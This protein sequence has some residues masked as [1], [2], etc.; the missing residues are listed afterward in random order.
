VECTHARDLALLA[1]D[2]ALPDAD[3]GALDAHLAECADCRRYA[4]DAQAV[5]GALAGARAPEV[6]LSLAFRL[7]NL[8]LTGRAGR[9]VV[10]LRFW[11]AAAAGFLFFAAS[12]AVAFLSREPA[13]ISSAASTYA[14]DQAIDRALADVASAIQRGALGMDDSFA[15]TAVG[16]RPA[17]RPGALRF[18]ETLQQIGG[19]IEALSGPIFEDGSR[20][21]G[22]QG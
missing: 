12:L 2:G 17:S 1:A 21:E 15:M 9:A 3:R 19:Q 7:T 11:A 18:D 8:A 6:P 22:G 10:R 14:S 13:A 16:S 4:Q 5:L 20:E